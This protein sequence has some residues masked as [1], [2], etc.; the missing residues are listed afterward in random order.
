MCCSSQHDINPFATDHVLAP[1]D[2]LSAG[3]GEAAAGDLGLELK[4]KDGSTMRLHYDT[5][6]DRQ[7]WLE[8]LGA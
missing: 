6:P 4:M 8:M 1:Y 5:E 3:T 7:M 2:V